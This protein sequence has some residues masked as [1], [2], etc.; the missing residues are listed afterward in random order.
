MTLNVSVPQL[1]TVW[2]I[3][4]SRSSPTV[5]TKFFSYYSYWL[6]LVIYF[7]TV[8]VLYPPP[9]FFPLEKEINIFSSKL[10]W[11]W[12]SAIWCSLLSLVSFF[13]WVGGCVC[14]CMCVLLFIIWQRDCPSM[15]HK[16]GFSVDVWSTLQ[17]DNHHDDVNDV[18]FPAMGCNGCK[19]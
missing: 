16:H 14:V 10:E 5:S 2:I 11:L 17:A 18:Y 9:S 3:P 7:T 19:K 8:I 13:G 6:V 12:Q 1:R 4:T 15:H